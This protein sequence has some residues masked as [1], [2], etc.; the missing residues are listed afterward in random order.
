MPGLSKDVREYRFGLLRD[1]MRAHGYD[2]LAFTGSDWFEWISNYGLHDQAF[3][4]PFLLIVTANGRSFALTS[5]LSRN[6]IAAQAQRGA[7]WLDSVSHYAESPDR[8]RHRWVASQWREMVAE[9]LRTAG[10][11]RARIAAT[12][13]SEWLVDAAS[14]LPGLELTRANVELHN[15]RRVKHSE[16]IATMRCCAALTDWALKLYREELRPGRLLSE[17]DHI[18]AARLIA[19]A[20][21]RF[22][23]SRF[24]V[25]GLKTISGRLAAG[26]DGHGRI[27]QVLEADSITMTSLATRLEGLA[28]E[29][30]RPWLVGAPDRRTLELF[31]CARAAQ[32]AGIE[33]VVAGR[34][35]CGIHDAAQRVFDAAG[36]GEQL[37]IRSG[38]GIGV[39]Q[40]DFPVD[41]PFDGRP[42]LER[43]VYAVEPALYFPDFGVFRFADTVAVGAAAP[44]RLTTASKDRSALTLN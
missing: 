40:H 14:A 17:A 33:A 10:L 8:T 9:A 20:A 7:W 3:E 30:A 39:V 42:L 34:P 21:R 1:F 5:E 24:A 29:L 6:P 16:E 4:R 12:S 32:E 2:A 43:E 31:E 44:E 28:M 25:R 37:R 11:H 13:Q 38:H 41:V 22:P 27:D 36:Y 19:E 26:A 18:V 23:D 15:L 35:I